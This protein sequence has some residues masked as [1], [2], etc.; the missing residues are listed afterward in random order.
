MRE[1]TF[2]SADFPAF[3]NLSISTPNE[4]VPLAA[5]GTV[6]ALAAPEIDAKVRSNVVVTLTRFA[7]GYDLRTASEALRVDTSKLLNVQVVGEGREEIGGRDSY[8]LEIAYTSEVGVTI[9]QSYRLFVV[10]E[11]HTCDLVHATGSCGGDE[12]EEVLPVLREIVRSVAA[13]A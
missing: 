12:A 2:P 1:H 3:P 10:E 8:L 11:G 13:N 9:V 5:P 6:I 4:W 7:K